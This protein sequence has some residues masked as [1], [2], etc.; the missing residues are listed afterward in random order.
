MARRRSSAK[1]G[2][3]KTPI[4]NYILIALAVVAALFFLNKLFKGSGT[5]ELGE[6]TK[7]FSIAKYRDGASR[8]ASAGNSYVFEGRVE[9]IK[10]GQTGR[11]IMISM[12]G[13]QDERLPLFLP[14]SVDNDVNVTL[15]DRFIFQVECRSGRDAN[16]DLVKGIFIINKIAVV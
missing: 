12:E 9:D 13:N 6:P 11:I 3:K 14:Q 1:K 15:Y 7:G 8:Y 4:A 5:T 10:E 16:G 2:G